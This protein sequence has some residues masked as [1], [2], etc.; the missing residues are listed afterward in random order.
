MGT[1]PNHMFFTASKITH[2]RDW[3]FFPRTRELNEHHTPN[4]SQSTEIPASSES[5]V[6]LHY[7][8][9]INKH[10]KAVYE[11]FN[12]TLNV[13][14]LSARREAQQ[15]PTCCAYTGALRVTA[16]LLPEEK[17]LP[18]AVVITALPHENNFCFPVTTWFA[19]PAGYMC[20]A[21]GSVLPLV[22]CSEQQRI[23][24]TEK[25]SLSVWCS[26]QQL[27]TG[28]ITSERVL[29][30]SPASTREDIP[31]RPSH[32]AYLC[33]SGQATLPWENENG[34]NCPA[35]YWPSLCLQRLLNTSQPLTLASAMVQHRK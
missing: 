35:L 28:K 33:L 30:S 18:N 13:I 29:Q 3:V 4:A 11:V 9:H 15:C 34:N 1:S 2:S 21:Q 31:S 24:A 17:F 10:L 16:V 14:L 19:G 20:L 12:Y 22:V 5:T 7:K 27:S 26:L 6:H 23:F 32:E 8:A 25:R